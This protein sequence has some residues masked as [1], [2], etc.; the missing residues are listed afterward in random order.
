M[1]E[2]TRKK[3][4]MSN[5]SSNTAGVEGTNIEGSATTNTAE[6][7]TNTDDNNNTS[8]ASSMPQP[9]STNDALISDTTASSR[10]YVYRDFAQDDTDYGG[11]A[12]GMES[13]LQQHGGGDGG[14]RGL[15][16]QK[17]PAKLN[18][19]LSDPG[20][21]DV[22]G[23]WVNEVKCSEAS[24]YCFVDVYCVLYII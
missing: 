20:E 3:V 22:D 9:S 8:T 18:A 4:N 13:S 10:P 24:D 17:L 14:V 23:C 6:G 21:F 5:D 12:V 16:N 15:T 2:P 11:D 1:V 19:M 7:G